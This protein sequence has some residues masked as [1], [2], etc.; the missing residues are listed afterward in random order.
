MNDLLVAEHDG[1]RTP[2]EA[3]LTGVLR[4]VSSVR[5]TVAVDNHLTNVTIPPGS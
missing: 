5:L 2:F 3:D 4:G 1:G